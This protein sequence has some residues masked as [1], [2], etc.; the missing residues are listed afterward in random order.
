MKPRRS[1][2]L[3]VLPA[4]DAAA[5]LGSFRAAAEEL[6]LTPSAISHQ[7]RT[8]EEA[9]GVKL[10]RRLAR[11]LVLSDAGRAYAR[12]VRGALDRLED[13]AERLSGGGAMTRVRISMPDF[14]ARLFVLPQVERFRARHPE[15]ELEIDT[16]FEL[17]DLEAGGVDAAIRLGKGSWPE[18]DSHLVSPLVATFVASPELAANARSLSDA[19]RLPVVCLKGQESLTRD[20]LARIGLRAAPSAMLRVDSCSGLVQAA[21]EGLGVAV[22]Y[23][24]PARGFEGTERLT[25]LPGGPLPA[26]FSMYFVCRR[27]DHDRPEIGALRDWV[28]APSFCAPRPQPVARRAP[29]R[30]SAT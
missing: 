9:V 17:R 26:P 10:F 14:V 19:A 2:P 13:E 28:L 30:I 24:P 20:S 25:R 12:T 4:F 11:G 5:R 27:D 1:L 6:H 3:H 21:E 29:A 22:L 16:G 23:L 15:I 7:I 18:L 8:L